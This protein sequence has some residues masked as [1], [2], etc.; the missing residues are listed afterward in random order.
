MALDF[1]RIYTLECYLFIAGMFALLRYG[2]LEPVIY[3]SNIWEAFT[4]GEWDKWNEG[5]TPG[6][7]QRAGSMVSKED[8]V[9][10]IDVS[11]G[12]ADS[13]RRHRREGGDLWDGLIF[14]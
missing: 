14:F 4:F 10:E 8:S 6:R 1:R 3:P 11:F 13:L 5:R 2:L 7:G 12:F 9:N